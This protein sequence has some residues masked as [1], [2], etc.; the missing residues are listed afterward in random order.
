MRKR[1]R[2]ESTSTQEG[3]KREEYPISPSSRKKRKKKDF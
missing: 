1:G 3:R 2:G